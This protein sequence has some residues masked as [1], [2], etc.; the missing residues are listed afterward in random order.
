M[1]LVPI[2][3]DVHKRELRKTI[4]KSLD[5]FEA[6]MAGRGSMEDRRKAFSNRVVQTFDIDGPV[7]LAH[8][9]SEAFRRDK[10]ARYYLAGP[11]TF[12]ID[13]PFN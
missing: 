2:D 13:E 8:P 1:E 7:S 10:D 3:K 11:K 9:P 5:R 12:D 6:I 4:E